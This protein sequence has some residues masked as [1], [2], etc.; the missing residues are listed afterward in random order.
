MVS[1]ASIQ[2]AALM[3]LVTRRINTVKYFSCGCMHKDKEKR[4]SY[5]TMS[6]VV[7]PV[8]IIQCSKEE[9]FYIYS[10]TQIICFALI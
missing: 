7:I 10:K 2:T 8:S 1:Y 3:L 4:T 6:H 9:N 5:F